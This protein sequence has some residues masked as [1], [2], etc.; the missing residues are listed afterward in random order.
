MRGDKT[1]APWYR[2]GNVWRG[3]GLVVEGGGGGWWRDRNVWRGRG[4]VVEG[5]GGWCEV[6]VPSNQ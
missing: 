4:L 5:G 3:S 6:I 2:D 1:Q